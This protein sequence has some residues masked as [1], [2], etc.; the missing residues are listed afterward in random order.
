[1][2]I[3]Q[4]KAKKINPKVEFYYTTDSKEYSQTLALLKTKEE[5]LEELDEQENKFPDSI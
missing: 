4:K 1:L 5:Q 2:R 3:L